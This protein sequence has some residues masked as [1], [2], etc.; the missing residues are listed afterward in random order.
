MRVA[1]SQV[2]STS[3]LAGQAFGPCAAIEQFLAPEFVEERSTLDLAF[4]SVS[5]VQLS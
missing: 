5:W 3:M 1:T 4:E 2:K